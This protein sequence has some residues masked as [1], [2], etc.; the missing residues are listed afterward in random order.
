MVPV[1]REYTCPEDDEIPTLK[2]FA[3]LYVYL[4][5]R[6]VNHPQHHPHDRIRGVL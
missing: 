2:F 3:N 1:H 6:D 5:Q 4:N